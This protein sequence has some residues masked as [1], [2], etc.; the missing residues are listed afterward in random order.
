MRDLSDF[1]RE[2]IVS[3][4]LAG[5]SVTEMA[6]VSRAAVSKVMTAYAHHGKTTLAK[7]NS[8]RKPK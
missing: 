3:G 7:R 4:R 6:T 1:Q 5:A 2:R 8:V